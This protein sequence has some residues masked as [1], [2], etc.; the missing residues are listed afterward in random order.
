M[1]K[2]QNHS[3]FERKGEKM[4]RKDEIL[5]YIKENRPNEL[6]LLSPLVDEVVFLEERLEELRKNPFIEIHPV[7][8]TKQRPTQSAKLYKE[9]LQQYNNCMKTVLVKSGGEDSDDT[10]PLRDF[11]KKRLETR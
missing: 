5:N 10:S 2:V 7:D 3:H 8:K 9:L 6:V 4:T 1:E 11:M